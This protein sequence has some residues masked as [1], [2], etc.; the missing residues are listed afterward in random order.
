MDFKDQLKIAYDADAQRRDDNESTREAWKLSLREQFAYLVK[1][2]GKLT[3]L[4]LGTGVGIDSAFFQTQ[5]L[6]VLATDLSSQMI[7]RCRKRGLN[8][9][10]IDLYELM[11]LGATFDA[12]YSLN[13]LLHVPRKDLEK[14]LGII[15]D[16]LIPNGI[17][18]YGVY[19]GVDEEKVITD[20]KKMNLPRF[21]SLLTDEAL[22]KAVAPKFDVIKFETIVIGSDQPGFHFQ[23]LFLRKR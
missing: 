1:S 14:V 11:N 5:M 13:V 18:F 2:E 19:G 15:H 21:F 9:R 7:E 17:F 12:T 6:D 4:E 10:A 22:L 3:V 16:A 20:A 23:A 8:A